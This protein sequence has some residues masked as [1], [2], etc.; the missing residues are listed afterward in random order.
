MSHFYRLILRVAPGGSRRHDEWIAGTLAEITDILREDLQSGVGAYHAICYGEQVMEIECWQDRERVARC[1][2]HPCLTLE[3]D[4]DGVRDTI[5]F[6]GSVAVGYDFEADEERPEDAWLS[7][8]LLDERVMITAHIDWSGLALPTLA[9]APLQPGEEAELI[10]DPETG[11]ETMEY[12]HHL[13]W[14]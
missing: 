2:V 5:T 1:D 7:S 6:D 13:L 3:L 9:G 12:G 8:R 10:E 11:V 14:G 4:D